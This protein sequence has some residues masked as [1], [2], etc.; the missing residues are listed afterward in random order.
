MST[1]QQCWK[2]C[3]SAFAWRDGS[4]IRTVQAL[5]TKELEKGGIFVYGCNHPSMITLAKT[6]PSYLW[7]EVGVRLYVADIPDEDR[8]RP[9]QAS[10]ELSGATRAITACTHCRYHKT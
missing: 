6:T 3:M 10:G 9:F 8:R 1:E 2:N 4:S 5:T 7:D